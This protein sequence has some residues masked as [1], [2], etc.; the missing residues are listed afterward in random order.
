MLHPALARVLATA[1]TED[2]QREAARRRNIRLARRVAHEQRLEGTSIAGHQPAW[3]R[4]VSSAHPGPRH[5]T[6]RGSSNSPMPTPPGRRRPLGAES[7]D[8]SGVQ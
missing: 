4:W 5:D 1:H 7:R 8:R 2:L 6:N 3:L